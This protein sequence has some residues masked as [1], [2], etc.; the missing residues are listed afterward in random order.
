MAPPFTQHTACS[1]SQRV[2]HYCVHLCAEWCFV[3]F[4]FTRTRTS[5]RAYTPAT[6]QLD[7]HTYAF[8]N[9]CIKLWKSCLCL[10]T[11][12]WKFH[13]KNAVSSKAGPFP[14][15]ASD[16]SPRSRCLLQA[17]TPSAGPWALLFIAVAHSASTYFLTWLVWVLAFVSRVVHP[18]CLPETSRV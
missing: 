11:G 16:L 10:K 5:L 15:Q 13:S 9:V 18:R 17:V 4:H 6:L 14:L 3:A 2:G 12:K 8:F 7:L 1:C